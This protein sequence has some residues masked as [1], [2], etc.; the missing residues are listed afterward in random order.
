MLAEFITLQLGERVLDLGCGNGYLA[1]A[2][3]C[4]FPACREMVGADCV[5]D[6]V[7]TAEA[8]AKRIQSLPGVRMAPIRFVITDITRES[9]TEEP[10]DVCV[11]NPPFFPVDA[12]KPPR[13]STKQLA[14]QEISLTMET[15]LDAA[16]RNSARTSRL[17]LVYPFRRWE[18]L[19]IA[20]QKRGFYVKEMRHDPAVRRR[21]GGIVFVDFS[22]A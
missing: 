5:E 9:V 10:F 12:G 13:D 3:A 7:R 11:S 1:L 16:A 15:L 4:R 20:A 6:L 2:L 18:E 14:R 19:K 22:R 21:S 8:A 17:C